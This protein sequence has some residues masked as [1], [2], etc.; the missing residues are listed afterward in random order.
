M[1]TMMNKIYKS[2]VFTMNA[3]AFVVVAPKSEETVSRFMHSVDALVE[4]SGMHF[5]RD[6]PES[7]VAHLASGARGSWCQGEGGAAGRR[8]VDEDGVWRAVAP[9]ARWHTRGGR[10]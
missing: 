10:G 6:R 2:E 4:R 9:S 5:G 7:V 3:P 8:W 1:L